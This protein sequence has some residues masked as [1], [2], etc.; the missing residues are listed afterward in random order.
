MSMDR[1]DWTFQQL[2]SECNRL[3]NRLKATEAISRDR[4]KMIQELRAEIENKNLY[5]PVPSS[6]EVGS[7]FGEVHPWVV[8]DTPDGFVSYPIT[9][10]QWDV[11]GPL[12]ELENIKRG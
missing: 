9:P 8:L 3:E 7:I 11:I 10:K 1:E 12:M 6:V 5:K 2:I 4:L